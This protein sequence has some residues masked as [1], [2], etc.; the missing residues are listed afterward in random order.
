V[1]KQNLEKSPVKLCGE[2]P[3]SMKTAQRQKHIALT[4]LDPKFSEAANMVD[5]NQE[6]FLAEHQG[7]ER[8]KHVS[9]KNTACCNK[10]HLTTLCQA[11]WEQ[12]DLQHLRGQ[13][14]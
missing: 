4:L 6:L 10:I 3:A 11:C 5:P 1:P 12:N 7:V 13:E 9:G 8:Q 2:V 14:Q